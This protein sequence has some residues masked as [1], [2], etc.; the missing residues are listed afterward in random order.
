[1]YQQEE[2]FRTVH[3]NVPTALYEEFV[4]LFPARGEKTII[5]NQ[6]ISYMIELGDRRNDFI[7][8]VFQE[9]LKGV[10]DDYPSRTKQPY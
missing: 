7:K 3:F 4:Q 9:L 2:K 8:L 6:V 1:M 5:L 10:E